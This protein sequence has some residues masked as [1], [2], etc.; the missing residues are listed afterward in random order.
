LQK[1]EEKT[2]AIEEADLVKMEGLKRGVILLP[3]A[4]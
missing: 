3:I 4:S 1:I 2:P